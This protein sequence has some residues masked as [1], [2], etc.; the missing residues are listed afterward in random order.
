MTLACERI[1]EAVL[2]APVR[3]SGSDLIYH[4]PNHDDKHP[5]LKINPKKNCFLCGPC[6]AQ[7]GPWNLAAFL[8]RINLKDKPTVTTWLRDRGLLDGSGPAA[9]NAGQQQESLEANSAARE[10]ETA[11]RQKGKPEAVYDYVNLQGHLVYQVVR[12]PGKQF[13]QRRPAGPD[14][15]MWNLDGVQPLPYRLPEVLKTERVFIAEGEKDVETLRQLGPTATTNSGG[16][17]KWRPEFADYFQGKDV[18]IFPDNDEPGRKHAEAIAASLQGKARSLKVVALP[19][20]GERGD[21]SDFVA[22]Y[23]EEAKNLLLA[24]AADAPEWQP[25][26]SAF[27]PGAVE[28]AD[29]AV[30]TFEEVAEQQLEWVWLRRF[31]RGKLSLILGDPGVSKSVLLLDIAARISRGSSFPDGAP[32]CQ[33]AV[34]V[35]SAEDSKEDTIKPRLRAAGADCSRVVWFPPTVTEEV[36]G[37]RRSRT[38]SLEKDLDRLKAV[39]LEHAAVALIFDPISSFLGR[40]SGDSETEV[41]GAL[42]PLITMAARTRVAV[43]AIRHWRKAEGPAIYRALGSMG[44]V[45]AARVAYGVAPDPQNPGRAA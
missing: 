31:P 29:D 39:I 40:V 33:G 38:F 42:T 18:A 12:Y 41:R 19:G 23:G 35:L 32:G 44:F 1:A 26:A 6:A 2:G 17:G 20:L 21:V 45:A 25:S 4:C 3:T 30:R 9:R 15:W 37:Q 11:G 28:A 43:L 8:A 5:S 7:G 24:A 10:N 27:T 16:A 22:K 34:I 14:R 13:R 36:S